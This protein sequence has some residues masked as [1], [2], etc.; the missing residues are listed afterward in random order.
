MNNIATYII[1]KLTIN[2][3]TESQINYY[4]CDIAKEINMPEW[5]YNFRKNK[6]RNNN[7]KLWYAVYIY[8]YKNGPSKRDDIIKVLKPNGK[9]SG[10]SQFFSAMVKYG[11]IESGTGKDRGLQFI[12]DPK[13]WKDF[14]EDSYIS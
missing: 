7:N 10:Y 13:N 4:T 3:D 1:E 8:L 12:K 6:I 14:R 5:A 2:K 11:L 9:P